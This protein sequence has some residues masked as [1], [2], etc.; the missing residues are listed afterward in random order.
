MPQN[1]SSDTERRNESDDSVRKPTRIR[2]F[3]LAALFCLAAFTYLDRVCISLATPWIIHDLG[4]SPLQMGMVFSVFAAAYA[5]F[6]VPTGWLGDRLGPRRVLARVLGWWSIFTAATGLTQ[7]FS[8]LMIVRFFFGV[9]E[10]GAYPN[11]TRAVASWFP[12]ERRGVAMGTI[13]MGSRL[14]AALTPPLVL[15]S[16]RHVGWRVTFQIL[17]ALGLLLAVLWYAWF[18]DKPSEVRT[19]N[20]DEAELIAGSGGLI[21]DP[22]NT[23]VPWKTIMASANLWAVNAMYFTLGFTYY[24]YISWFPTYLVKHRDVPLS[25]LALYASMPLIFSTVASL[26]GGVVTDRLVCR[27]GVA[28]ARRAVGMLGCAGAAICLICGVLS[29][30]VFSSVILISFAAGAS[31]FTLAA[32]WASCADI[33]GAAAG[34]VSG[35]MNMTGNIGAALSPALMGLLIEKTANWNITFYIA[36]ILNIVGMALWFFIHA[37]QPLIPSMEASVAG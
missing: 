13:W 37:D 23:A 36:A 25:Q 2:Y 32:A 24:L 17:G 7:G 27:F 8:S 21:T 20:A 4:L 3:V 1:S 19:V 35:A 30:D 33:G 28:W 12:R 34:T 9:G 11:M 14:G 26:A 18:R 29:R 6:E 5:L 22:G 10:A 16:I 31:D 15:F